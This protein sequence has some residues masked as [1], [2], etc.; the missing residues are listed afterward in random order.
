MK[1]AWNEIKFYKLRY[2]LIMLIIVLL[3]MMVLFI[4]GLAQ[5]L[6]RENVS[7][8][9]QLK[10][11]H[12]IIQDMKAPQIEKSQ[13]TKKQQSKVENIINTKPLKMKQQTLNVKGENNEDV[14]A[15]DSSLQHK[16]K[17][18]KGHYPKNDNQIVVNEKLTGKGINIGDQV[19]FKNQEKA[20]KVT[21]FLKDA[22]YSHSSIVMMN[23][24][25]FSD[26]KGQY[27]T[28]YPINKLSKHEQQQLKDITGIQV[29]DENELKDNI[30]SY[31]AEQAPL[32]MMIVS[33]F[34]I[35]AIVLSAF[36]YVM[37]IQKVSEIGILKAI[38]IKTRHLLKSL[39]SQILMITLL[40]VLISV[41]MIISVSF[42]I[43][44]TMPY[45]LAYANYILVIVIFILVA[46]IG[47]LLSF[48][49]VVKIDP[50]D[51]IGGGE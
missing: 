37:T 27:A 31:K 16:F 15:I 12:Y 6:G 21:G 2:I 20:Y 22:M 39:T 23:Q 42:I 26:I 51:A 4:S 13:L 10:S 47:S 3:S 5:G 9:S 1:L 34:V 25:G 49:K 44:V 40:S 11:K 43:P 45:H 8:F 38:G 14:L 19:Q 18:S 36:F 35:S 46:C 24:Q 33:L 30:A 48:I 28:F 7:L 17:L 29:T 50:L 41:A 32:N